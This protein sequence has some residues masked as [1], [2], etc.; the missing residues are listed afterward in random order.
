MPGTPIPPLAGAAL[1]WLLIICLPPPALPA[2][3]DVRH[4]PP[5]PSWMSEYAQADESQRDQLMRAHLPEAADRFHRLL[6]HWSAESTGQAAKPEG[7]SLREVIRDFAERL[8]RMEDPSSTNRS[9]EF[10]R[11]CEMTDEHAR[12]RLLALVACNHAI[13][14]WMRSDPQVDEPFRSANEAT[15]ELAALGSSAQDTDLL[16]RAAMLRALLAQDA[17]VPRSETESALLDLIAQMKRDGFSLDRRVMAA[18]LDLALLSLSPESA[19]PSLRA[20]EHLTKAR[21]LAPRMD[22][23]DGIH[24]TL[25]SLEL[26]HFQRTEQW[27]AAVSAGLELWERLPKE[28]ETVLAD[29]AGPLRDDALRGLGDVLLQVG[30]VLHVADHGTVAEQVLKYGVDLPLRD[31][32]QKAKLHLLLGQT[33]EGLGFPHEGLTRAGAAMTLLASEPSR[34]QEVA[35]LQFQAE[36]LRASS[37]ALLDRTTEAARYLHVASSLRESLGESADARRLLRRHEI[38]SGLVAAMNG[39]LVEALRISEHAAMGAQTGDATNEQLQALWQATRI[40]LLL[41]DT[42]EALEHSLRAESA[43]STIRRDGD[44]A[45]VCSALGHADVLVTAARFDEAARHLEA[46]MRRQASFLEQRPALRGESLCLLT[47]ARWR[48]WRLSERKP[49]FGMTLIRD[50]DQALVAWQQPSRPRGSGSEVLLQQ[51]R[52][53]E[54]RQEITFDLGNPSPEQDIEAMIEAAF[55]RAATHDGIAATEHLTWNRALAHRSLIRARLLDHRGEWDK[56]FRA[57]SDAASIEDRLRNALTSRAPDGLSARFESIHDR[58]AGL[59]FRA[60]VA[61]PSRARAEQALLFLERMR[62]KSLRTLLVSARNSGGAEPWQDRVSSG[63]SVEEPQPLTVRSLRN[64]LRPD[65]AAIVYSFTS[66]GSFAVV[67]R[68][69]R[70][71]VLELS[72][73]RTAIE[74]MT[75]SLLANLSGGPNR[76]R[77]LALRHYGHELYRV[78]LH[79]L[80]S[81]LTGASD[82]IIVADATL[83]GLPFALLR[84]KPPLQ[85]DDQPEFHQ[86]PLLLRRPELRSMVLTPS[87]SVFSVLTSKSSASPENRNALLL[88][89]PVAESTFPHLK[90]AESELRKLEQI[91]GE[92]HAAVLLGE[93][94]TRAR[95]LA[96]QPGRFRV[97]HFATHTTFGNSDA[98]G[99]SLL[100]SSDSGGARGE[101]RMKD[102]AA[103]KLTNTEWVILSAC[104]SADGRQA[105]LEGRLGLPRAFLVAGARSVLATVVPVA[106]G[107]SAEFMVSLHEQL[108][109]GKLLSEALL[110]EQRRFCDQPSKSWPGSWAPYVAIGRH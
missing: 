72:E 91:Y 6:F 21:Q 50:L 11:H 1:L 60:A 56:A 89:S 101:L 103:L 41:G 17:R 52:A 33:A 32:R 92:E 78:L 22:K 37:S 100:L 108:H 40:R 57:Y 66:R 107:T 81:D 71:K 12:A 53:I 51:L 19:R 38:L 58:M 97:L 7:W 68:H 31:A 46:M 62:A 75:L 4:L 99:P 23:S 10:E 73:D 15:K 5:I 85:E 109:A 110:Y 34:H 14:E 16:R 87:L 20:E 61:S 74:R 63:N 13:S 45:R 39:D 64:L 49:E 44:W 83:E 70:T 25:L 48:L 43:A 88:G 95:F 104:A 93:H 36:L 80:E 59:L 55:E 54:L 105:G 24:T 47:E 98:A 2:Q 77:A 102:I 94:A 106:D 76:Y 79:P 82:L 18:H 3:G 30:F 90:A 27:D 8:D 35:L 26:E 67:H 84:T 29:D 86:D 65:Q 9:R 28:V 42:A 69:D 96:E